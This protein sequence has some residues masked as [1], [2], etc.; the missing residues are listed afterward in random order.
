LLTL[1]L[2]A[3]LALAFSAARAQEGRPAGQGGGQTSTAQTPAPAGNADNGRALYV[4]IGCYEC[5]NRDASGAGTGPRLAPDPLAWN[6]FSRQVRN[7]AN[8][9]PPYTAKALP[10]SDLADIYAFLKTI[11]KPPAAS[12]IP[13]LNGN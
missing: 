5:H 8:A 1:G 13:L 4:K 3:S 9:M 7:P 2:S 11:P 6:A 12:S 10:D